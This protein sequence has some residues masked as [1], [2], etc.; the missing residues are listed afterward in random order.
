M[1]GW[2]AQAQLTERF[3]EGWEGLARLF[4]HRRRPGRSYQ[5]L[6]KAASVGGDRVFGQFWACLR[7]TIPE[8]VEQRWNWYGWVVLTVDGSRIDAARTRCNERMLKIA[9]RDKTH[10]QW[11]VTVISHLP[12]NLI[13]DWR[14]GPGTSNERDHLRQMLPALPSST[15]LV[16][17]IGFCNFDLMWEF[18]CHQ[19]DFLIRVGGNT[20]LLA[21]VGRENVEGVGEHRYVYFYPLR[22]RA[23]P[24]SVCV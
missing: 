5:G 4:P 17:D 9:G 7:R 21:E 23:C 19:I 11:W 22:K 3:R 13:W 10:P 18:Y 24:H 20:T 14:Q 12:T 6:V 16:G 2:S 15:L 1:I 8:R